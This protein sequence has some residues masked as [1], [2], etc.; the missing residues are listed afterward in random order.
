MQR[1]WGIIARVLAKMVATVRSRG[2]MYKAMA[3]S[4]IFYGSEIWVVTGGY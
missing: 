4:V 3:Q 2:V 1:R